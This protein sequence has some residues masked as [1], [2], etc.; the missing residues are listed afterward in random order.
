MNEEARMGF[1]H[2]W[3]EYSGGR[4]LPPGRWCAWVRLWGHGVHVSNRARSEAMF[5]ERY[6]YTRPLYLLGLRFERLK[7]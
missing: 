7:P 6:G 4:S 3:L 2:R 5:S 1:K